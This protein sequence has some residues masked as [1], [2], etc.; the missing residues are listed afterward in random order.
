MAIARWSFGTIVE[1]QMW[2]GKAARRRKLPFT[3]AALLVDLAKLP[4]Q[5]S[6]QLFDAAHGVGVRRNVPG[7][8]AVSQDL[9]LQFNAFVLRGTVGLPASFL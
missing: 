8:L 4:L 3:E 7:K 5:V 9:H 1:S 2:I 6:N